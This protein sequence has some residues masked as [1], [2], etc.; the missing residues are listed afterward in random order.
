MKPELNWAAL[1]KVKPLEYLVRF[2]FGGLISVG[3]AALGA[4]WGPGVGGLFLAFPAILPA[5]LT[6][7]KEKGGTRQACDDARGAVLGSLGLC[8]FALTVVGGGR[9]PLVQVLLLATAAWTLTSVALWW[10]AYRN[11]NA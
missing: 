9:A 10:V 11:E 2:A 8:A 6:L 5:S 1:H 4:H 7:L 3:A